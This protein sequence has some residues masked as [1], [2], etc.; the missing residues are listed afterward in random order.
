M[1][2]QPT[3]YDISWTENLL[4]TLKDGGE[5]II[6]ASMSTIKI[7]KK[8]MTYILVG[9]KKDEC[10]QRIVKVMSILGWKLNK[11]K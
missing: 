5:W 1:K 4:R 10:N 7:N 6:P 3:G 9:N 8:E 11:E 2:W